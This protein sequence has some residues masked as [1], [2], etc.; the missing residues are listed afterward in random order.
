M[1]RLKL[2]SGEMDGLGWRVGNSFKRDGGF[3]GAVSHGSVGSLSITSQHCSPVAVTQNSTPTSYGWPTI[4]TSCSNCATFTHVLTSTKR[5]LLLICSSDPS[6]MT[7]TIGFE[8]VCKNQHIEKLANYNDDNIPAVYARTQLCVP[9]ALSSLEDVHTEGETHQRILTIGVS[10][11]YVQQGTRYQ[12]SSANHHS[13]KEVTWKEEVTTNG[14]QMLH[15]KEHP[16]DCYK[17]LVD[18]S[19]VVAT[20]ISDVGNNG[21]KTIK[22]AVK[23]AVGCFFAWPKNQ[24]VLDLKAPPPSIIQM[25][26]ENKTAPKLQ[27]K[28]TNVY[29]YRDTM[30]KQ[31]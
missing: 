5:N 30:K 7:A 28:R 12:R 25:I 20:C 3:C 29:V 2:G 6:T 16:K 1:N 26:G 19:L 24:V 10:S 18:K 23:D 15:N 17:V 11:F 13:K 9:V 31:A 14:K 8:G 21:F 22:D 27:S 4:N